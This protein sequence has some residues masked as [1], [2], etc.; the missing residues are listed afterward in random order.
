MISAP[1]LWQRRQAIDYLQRR[2]ADRL[3]AQ[4]RQ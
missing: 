1:M 4:E 2:L 3:L